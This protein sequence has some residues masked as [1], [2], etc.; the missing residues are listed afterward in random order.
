VIKPFLFDSFQGLPKPNKKHDKFFREGQFPVPIESV[1]QRLIDFR[2]IIDI[3]DGWIPDTFRGLENVRYA[4][5][6]VDVDLYQ[7][8]LDSC[9]YFYPRLTPGGVMLFD[10]YGFPSTHG[11]KVAVDEYFADK[12]ERPIALITGQAVVLKVPPQ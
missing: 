11:E 12:P 8:T 4:F 7:S 2:S 1:K 6:H 10:E 3:R 5:V 9:V